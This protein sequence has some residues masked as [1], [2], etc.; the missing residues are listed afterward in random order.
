MAGRILELKN[1]KTSFFTQAGEVEAVRGISFHVD[2]GEAI[3]IVGESGSGKSVTA[4][5]IMKLLQAP[6]KITGGQV[7][8]KGNDLVKKKDRE[9]KNIRGNEMSIIFQDSTMSLNPVFT[10][11][12]QVME[13]ILNHQKISKEKAKVKAIEILRLV[14][15]TSAEKRLNHYPHEFSGGMRQRVIIGMALSCE[16]DLLLADEPTTALDSTIQAQILELMRDLKDRW[17]TSILLITHNLGIAADFCSRIV[18]MYNGLIMEEGPV[19][20]IFFNSKHPYTRGLIESIP[21]VIPKGH[22][23]RLASIEGTP[24]D[25]L[26]PPIGCPFM[27]RCDYAMKICKLKEPPYFRVGTYHRSMCWLLHKDAPKT[28]PWVNRGYYSNDR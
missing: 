22:K 25:S 2:K 3:G 20:K 15:I 10:V 6:G 19:E 5:S 1:L 4:L 17:D 18:V 16:P 13:T 28:A 26:N 11:G 7:L 23:R 14:G 21:G 12:N 8:F 9:M 27:P 24:P